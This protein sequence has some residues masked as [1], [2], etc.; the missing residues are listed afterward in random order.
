M[1][2]PATSYRLS[3][4]T[5][6]LRIMMKYFFQLIRE[7]YMKNYNLKGGLLSGG[8]TTRVHHYPNL[9]IKTIVCRL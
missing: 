7:D 4:Q 6:K 3:Y 2:L 8:L 1:D 5:I 9:F